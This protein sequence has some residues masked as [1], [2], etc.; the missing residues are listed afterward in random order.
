MTISYP[1]N[2]YTLKNGLISIAL[3]A[4]TAHLFYIMELLVY[5]EKIKSIRIGLYKCQGSYLTIYLTYA[6]IF[7]CIILMNIGTV[8]M[9]L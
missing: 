9:I 8:T 3:M 5:Q 7:F 1:S 6:Y 2:N 4:T